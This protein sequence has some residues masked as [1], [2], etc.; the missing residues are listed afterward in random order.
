MAVP[1]SNVLKLSKGYQPKCCHITLALEYPLSALK[2]QLKIAANMQE[3]SQ[4]TRHCNTGHSSISQPSYVLGQLTAILPWFLDVF[5]S[6]GAEFPDKKA[7]KFLHVLINTR[8]ISSSGGQEEGKEIGAIWIFQQKL[9][10]FHDVMK[11][12]YNVVRTCVQ[13]ILANIR[14][15]IP[16]IRPSLALVV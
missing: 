1:H 14:P 3:T 7:P 5:A 15:K 13:E 9:E 6:G 11:K 4:P 2:R 10:K 12:L 16:R 8:N